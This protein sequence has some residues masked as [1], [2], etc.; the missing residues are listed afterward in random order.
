MVTPSAGDIRGGDL[1]AT[2]AVNI[3]LEGELSPAPKVGFPAPLFTLSDLEGNEVSLADLRGKAVVINFW[4]T[5]CPPCRAEIPDLEAVYQK[6]NSQGVEFLGVDLLENREP[7]ARY[8]ART[9]MS[10]TVLL[11]GEALVSRAYSLTALPTTYFLDRDGIIRDKRIGK[12]GEKEI[13]ERL[14]EALGTVSEE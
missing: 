10:Y 13:E 12:M 11:D 6:Y 5:W 7:V 1:S 2:G 14:L 9:G 8:V 4:A 3:T